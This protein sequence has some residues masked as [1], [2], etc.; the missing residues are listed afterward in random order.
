MEEVE[1]EWFIA[2][3]TGFGTL[4]ALSGL[5]SYIGLF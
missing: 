4:S 5:K 1:G 3:L 2:T